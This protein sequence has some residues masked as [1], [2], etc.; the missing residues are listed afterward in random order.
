MRPAP[1]RKAEEGGV[2]DSLTWAILS[3][4]DLGSAVG[5]LLRELGQRTVTTLAGRSDRT[6]EGCRRAGIEALPDLQ[7]VVA[8]ADVVMSVVRPEAALPLARLVVAGDSR[9]AGQ[10]YVDAN[11]LALRDLRE[12]AGVVRAA[13]GPF[14][15][16]A[17]HG[18]AAYAGRNRLREAGSLFL[19]GDAVETVAAVFAPALRIVRLGSE[20]G[21]ATAL[22]LL[23]SAVNKG[24]SALFA[25]AGMA[26]ARAGLLD[27]TLAAL[28]FHYPHLTADLER[29]LPSYARHAARRAVEMEGL[30]EM[31]TDL[32]V[33]PDMA[34][35]SARRIARIAAR[36]AP[37]ED[38]ATFSARDLLDALGRIPDRGGP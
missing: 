21:R 30:A 38:D 23:V 15:D 2:A 4:G 5:K 3:P 17:F 12:I 11:S 28:R 29:Q 27:E 9:R 10:L 22:K 13:G 7:S 26:A 32:G 1:K 35:A 24:M 19:A 36:L 6:R 31:A 34:A 33:E 8:E 20:A 25:E 37:G 18:A 16:A 14:L